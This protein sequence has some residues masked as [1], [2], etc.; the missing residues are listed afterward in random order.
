MLGT[1]NSSVERESISD[2]DVEEEGHAWWTGHKPEFMLELRY[3][4]GDKAVYSYGDLRGAKF[5]KVLTLFFDTATITIVGKGL[6]ELLSG[7]RRHCVRYIQQH[8]ADPMFERNRIQGGYVDTIEIKE[9]D[10]E[11]LGKS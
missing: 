11:A 4:N 9:P 6:G 10:L 5:G 1:R 3:K 2:D 7:L 8:H